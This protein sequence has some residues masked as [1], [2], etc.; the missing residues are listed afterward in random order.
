MTLDLQKYRMKKIITLLG[1]ITLTAC[2]NTEGDFIIE[3]GLLIAQ[4]T[5]LSPIND[6]RIARFVGY[7]L[8]DKN[9]IVYAGPDK[10]MVKGKFATIDGK[11]K[12]VMPGLIDSH[13][14][15]A[16]MAG[17]IWQHQKKYPELVEAYFSQ[18]P[19]SFLYYGY[20]TLI[21]V[22]NYAP[23]I[24][25]KIQNRP[26]RPDIHTCGNQIQVMNDFMMEMEGYPIE[27]RLQSPFLFDRYNENVQIPDTIDLEP[28]TPKAIIADIARNQHAVCAKTLYE[29]ESSFF[30]RSW[31][32]PSIKVM[33]DLVKEAHEEG[34]PVIMHAPSYN[35]QRFALEAGVDI[36]AHS[37]WNWYGNPEQF[38][39]TTFTSAH[40][41]LLKQIA[42]KGIGYQPTFRAIYG[43]VDLMEGDFINDPALERVYPTA[44]LNWLKT[45]EGQWGKQKILHRAKI[46]NAIDPEHFQPLRSQF[47]TDEAMFKGIQDIL[48]DRM[49]VVMKLLADHGAN[50]LFATDGVA[51]NMSTNP[52]GYNGYLEMQ[53]WVNA[54]IPLSQLF[55]A[56]TYNNAKAFHLLEEY[57]S[58]EAGKMAN[59]L[60]L[61]EDPL[62]AVMA[63]DAIDHII[64]QGQ[65]VARSALS[66]EGL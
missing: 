35:G 41:E 21:D 15:L 61:N 25:E 32:L 26:I 66:A 50:L 4:A 52:P 12:Y 22:N 48:K 43:E 3:D 55:F 45:D 6:G 27:E 9:Q 14:H 2:Q 47:E 13:V 62:V 56:V 58:I 31:E 63:Y 57:G 5:V 37:M 8:I 40:E 18:L 44:Y 28:H 20:T 19:K 65:P 11:G 10:P 46:L 16:N 60:L 49:D 24:I 29:D 36:L 23:E 42:E 39:D 7:V 54:G 17:A 30:P 34:L 1:F 59:L 38:L 64:I 51:M 33:R 53:H